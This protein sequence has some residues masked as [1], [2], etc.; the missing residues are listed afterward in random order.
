MAKDFDGKPEAKFWTAAGDRSGRG[1]DCVLVWISP[2]LFVDVSDF[3]RICGVHGV[4]GILSRGESDSCAIRGFVDGI[5][6]G[7]DD[8]QYEALRRLHRAYGDGL[9]VHR[10]GRRGVQSRYSER[11]A[12]RRYSAN[13]A[14]HF[15]SARLRDQTGKELHRATPAGRS[16]AGQQAYDDALSG[17]AAF[18]DHRREWDDG[19]D[20]FH[21]EG[22]FIRGLFGIEPGYGTAGNPCLSESASEVDLARRSGGRVRSACSDAAESPCG[23]G[24]RG[25]PAACGTTCGTWTS[26]VCHLAR[27]S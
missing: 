5:G 21:T 13:R 1:R 16:A 27:G 3:V 17:E 11:H 26:L 12:T 14:L 2:V 23:A 4:A 8:A 20:L 22:R 7:P 10:T 19:G 24:A 9:C 18:L 25:G 15:G 6:G